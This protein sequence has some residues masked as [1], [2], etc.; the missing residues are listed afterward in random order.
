MVLALIDGEFTVK[1]YR[2]RAGGVVLQ[3]KNKAFQDIVVPEEAAFEVWVSS[4]NSRKKNDRSGSLADADS[5]YWLIG[6]SNAKNQ[7]TPAGH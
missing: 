7:K 1:R 6:L 5:L 3:A 4:G 2:L